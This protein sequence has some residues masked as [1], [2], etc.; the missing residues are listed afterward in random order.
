MI[1]SLDT[2]TRSPSLRWHHW[3]IRQTPSYRAAKKHK[4][5]LFDEH[6]RNARKD[7]SDDLSDQKNVSSALENVIQREAIA[8]KKEGR[9]PQ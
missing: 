4:D 5:D 2:V 8:A 1:E 7:Y 3:L 9:L 6:F